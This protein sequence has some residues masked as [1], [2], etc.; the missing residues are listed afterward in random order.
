MLLLL[1]CKETAVFITLG[2]GLYSFFFLRRKLPGI[3]LILISILGWIW[4][5]K[6]IMPLFTPTNSF[7][8]YNKMPFGKTYHENLLFILQ[9]PVDFLG[10]FFMPRKVTFYFKI[11]GSTGF[12]PVFCP[13]QYILLITSSLVIILGA[14]HQYGYFM[15]SSH[16][17]GHMLAFIYIAAIYGTA[18]LINLFSK[19][20]AY[21]KI[22]FLQIIFISIWDYI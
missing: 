7:L 5:T 9:K 10:F 2:L 6:F 16:Y 21:S 11:L 12:L 13:S 18:N 17:I 8:Y 20:K 4:E 14:A 15:L 22:I 1:A 19:R 3:I